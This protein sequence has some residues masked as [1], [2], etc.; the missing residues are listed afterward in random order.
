MI[1]VTLKEI[2]E[3]EELLEIGRKAVEATLITWRDSRISMLGRNNGL[4]V[5]ER[6]GRPSEVIRMGPEDA[7]RIGLRAIAA[8]LEGK[9]A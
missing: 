1:A 3:D 2:A 5:R 8:H 9:K 4:V 7:L 6:D